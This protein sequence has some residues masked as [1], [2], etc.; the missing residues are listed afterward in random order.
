MKTQN[1]DVPV[2]WRERC[3]VSQDLVD[4][5][6][7]AVCSLQ[8]AVWEMES[9]VTWVTRISSHPF[10]AKQ[11]PQALPGVFA[12][13]PGCSCISWGSVGEDME[14][15]VELHVAGWVEIFLNPHWPQNSNSKLPG[16]GLKCC[17]ACS[18]VS[19]QLCDS[20]GFMD[21]GLIRDFRLPHLQSH[22]VPPI[23]V[24][25][26]VTKMHYKKC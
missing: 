4:A 5:G 20:M 23:E 8:E 3:E 9:I 7:A 16:Q 10:P 13:A 19:H 24:I 6:G 1:A 11:E 17:C 14:W 15:H 2:R 18:S 26:A 21:T 25:F 12:C 22:P